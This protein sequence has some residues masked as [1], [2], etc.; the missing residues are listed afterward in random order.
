MF[1]NIP[2]NSNDKLFTKNDVNNYFNSII[3]NLSLY[4]GNV[5]P[6]YVPNY[7]INIKTILTYF[8][9]NIKINKIDSKWQDKNVYL[10]LLM[11]IV[12]KELIPKNIQHFMDNESP[13]KDLFPDPC[14]ECIN[15]KTNIRTLLSDIDKY[16]ECEYKILS[17]ELNTKYR[18][19]LDNNHK[20][21]ELPIERI[22]TAL[23]L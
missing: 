9:D 4:S 11:P 21:D 10:L 19:H 14:L 6:N 3:W 20:I 23:E 16:D 17:S 15:F 8:P 18:N 22:T 12:G 5:I 1:D 7:N 2:F 13:I